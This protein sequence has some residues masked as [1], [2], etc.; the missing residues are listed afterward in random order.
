MTAR[1]WRRIIDEAA[2]L[3][4]SAVQF[5][6]GEPT[7]HSH[8]VE[9]VGHA[10]GA[11]LR[12][13]V[14]SNLYRVRAEHRRLFEHPRV[15]L[16][17]SYYSDDAAEHDAV[18]GR[19]GSHDLLTELPGFE[20]TNLRRSTHGDRVEQQAGQPVFGV[21]PYG[22]PDVLSSR[23]VREYGGLWR[24]R[25]EKATSYGM[26]HRSRCRGSAGWRRQGIRRGRTGC[27]TGTGSR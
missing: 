17:T 24:L 25:C 15:S 8:F 14:C 23:A 5:I 13:R 6:G 2:A 16:A 26:S 1:D 20:P 19:R 21:I 18:T 10:V 3:G 22:R 9:L 11:G 12:A 27:S 4:T 7:L